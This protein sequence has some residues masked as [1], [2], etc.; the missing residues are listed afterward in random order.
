MGQNN[1]V[2]LTETTEPFLW[3]SYRKSL[4]GSDYEETSDKP[5]SKNTT[6]LPACT[7][8]K[9]QGHKRQENTEG[10]HKTRGVY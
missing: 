3:T 2:G 8:Q 7:L 6:K 5:T 1:I 10:N 4:P 9:Y